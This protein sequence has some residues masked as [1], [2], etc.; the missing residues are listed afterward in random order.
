MCI[1]RRLTASKDETATV[2]GGQIVQMGW[3]S[4]RNLI[5]HHIQGAITL[6]YLYVL[7]ADVGRV[8]YR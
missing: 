1:R 5:R 4:F 3:T 6:F 8:S 7:G 2:T